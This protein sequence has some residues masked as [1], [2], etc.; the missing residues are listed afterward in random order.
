MAELRLT[1][2]LALTP[3]PAVNLQF[4]GNLTNK[5]INFICRGE[6]ESPNS[7]FKPWDLWFYQPVKLPDE[8]QEIS[9][10]IL[11]PYL[12]KTKKKKDQFS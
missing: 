1:L 6:V 4:S 11:Q 8:S 12:P 7:L 2:S 10:I 5:N 3:F 9:E